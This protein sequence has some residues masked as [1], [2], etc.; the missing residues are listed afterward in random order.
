M[1]ARSSDKHFKYIIFNYFGKYTFI[2]L[3]ERQML[4]NARLTWTLKLFKA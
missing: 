4:L 2:K 3:K 1:S